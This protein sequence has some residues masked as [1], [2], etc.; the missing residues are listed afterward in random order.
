M[1]ASHLDIPNLLPPHHCQ[2]TRLFSILVDQTSQQCRGLTHINAKWSGKNTMLQ[3]L[4]IPPWFPQFGWDGFARTHRTNKCCN[5]LPHPLTHMYANPIQWSY[6]S[7]ATISYEALNEAERNCFNYR[8]SSCRIMAECT[9]RWL[10]PRWHRAS[11][12]PGF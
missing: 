2:I 1:D 5:C 7:D 6:L 11:L 3:L 9:F 12:C 4:T 10:K 8:L